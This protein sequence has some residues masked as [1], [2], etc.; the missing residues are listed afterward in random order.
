MTQCL[1]TCF[2]AFGFYFVCNKLSDSFRL[3]KRRKIASL[4][5]F[6]KR[7]GCGILIS[8]IVNNGLS[9]N[10]SGAFEE[11]AAIGV[12]VTEDYKQFLTYS[13][14]DIEAPFKAE[15][16]MCFEID[17][18]RYVIHITLLDETSYAEGIESINADN[19]V[20]TTKTEVRYNVK[21]HKFFLFHKETEERIRYEVK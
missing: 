10:A 1:P 14:D 6:N 13:N 12:L 4:K 19:K 3:I 15:A 11:Y 5:V 7:P 8:D 21:P 16:T 2:F 17:A 20:D 9:F 18:K